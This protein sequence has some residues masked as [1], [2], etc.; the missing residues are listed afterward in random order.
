MLTVRSGRLL[1]LLA[2]VCTLWGGCLSFNLFG[3]TIP[4]PPSFSYYSM[5]SFAPNTQ[6]AFCSNE[7]YPSADCFFEVNADLGQPLATA[8]WRENAGMT[9]GQF[10]GT[11]T[12][13]I[14]A[15]QI[16]HETANFM[17]Y[18]SHGLVAGNQALLCLR[19]CTGRTSGGTSGV[20]TSDIPNAWKGPNWLMLDACDVVVPGVGWESKFGGNLH[21][22][23]GWNTDVQSFYPSTGPAFLK[24]FTDAAI[25]S[26]TAYDAWLAAVS[27][28][29]QANLATMLL[30]Q[31]NRYDVIEAAGGVNFGPNGSINPVY[32]SWNGQALQPNVQ[33]LFT[34]PSMGY[35]LIAEPMDENGWIN[36]YGGN[37]VQHTYNQT[38]PVHTW[39]SQQAIVSHYPRSGGLHVTLGATGTAQGFDVNTAMQY[40]QNW[41]GNNGG[42]P[43]DAVLTYAGTLNDTPYQ[44]NAIQGAPYPNNL[45]YMFT[46]RHGSNSLLGGDKI[47]VLV[48][49]SGSLTRYTKRYE[50]WD[51]HCQ[52]YHYSYRTYYAPPWV[53]AFS[54][55]KYVRAWRALGQHTIRLKQDTQHI[56]RRAPA[57]I[58]GYAYCSSDMGALA[59][60]AIPCSVSRGPASN[61]YTDT[62][63]Q[64]PISSSEHL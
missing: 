63:F 57:T 49:D 50:Y 53:P 13:A 62:V 31:A 34:Q 32:Y 11:W 59:T 40:A 12:T 33:L 20:G 4:P 8:G 9:D 28:S 51:P 5:V 46:W 56:R 42:L 54:V 7:P 6:A 43:A 21:G 29:G 27:A 15:D 38:N 48:D 18:E 3:Q 30:P 14:T 23:M 2:G 16:T 55:D 36:Q 41:I 39:I 35:Q 52:C 47:T 19:N 24:A 44:Y 26:S 17:Y 22:I 1:V 45:E 25:K 60:V 64:M 37:N 61:T 10:D 58:A